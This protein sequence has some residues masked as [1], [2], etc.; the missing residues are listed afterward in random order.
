VAERRAQL[1]A[2]VSLLLGRDIEPGEYVMAGAYGQAGPAYRWARPLAFIVA[3]CWAASYGY[4]SY[5]FFAAGQSSPNP[6]AVFA[7]NA[8]L[9]LIAAASWR[10]PIYLALTTRSLYVVR[11]RPMGRK[12]ASAVSRTP[13]AAVTWTVTRSSPW[14]RRVRF[15]G[16]GLPATG[17][18]LV[19][20]GDWRADLDQLIT[21]LRASKSQPQAA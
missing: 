4:F 8:A 7:A 15:N 13:V 21:A 14:Q 17:L 19:T 5:Q 11:V 10:R 12:P 3:A 2:E 9:V 16:P 1:H 6:A 18:C 20:A